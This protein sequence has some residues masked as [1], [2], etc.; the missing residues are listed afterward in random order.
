MWLQY[1]IKTA[2]S[3]IPFLTLEIAPLRKEKLRFLK[4]QSNYKVG[5]RNYM[6]KRL[7]RLVSKE[8][9]KSMMKTIVERYG[10]VEKN[11]YFTKKRLLSEQDITTKFVLPMLRALNWDPFKI[12]REGPEIH[13]KGFRE[14]DIETTPQ[15]KARRGGLPDFS[16]RRVGSDVPFFVE[17][18]HTCLRLNPARDLKKYRD[19][20][21]VFLTSFRES[22]LV[23][24]GKNRKKEVCKKFVAC[25]PDLYVSKFDNLWNYVSNSYEAEGARSALKAWR[26]GKRHLKRK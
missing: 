14:R 16:L 19:S 7:K 3:R 20:H 13:E 10:F 12:T 25:S 1:F 5:I 21:L 6:N 17:V 2:A 4:I 26:H 8:Q 22:M 15:E 23:R 18:K 24:V 11:D 9:G